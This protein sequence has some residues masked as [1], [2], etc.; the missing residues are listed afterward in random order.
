MRS[1]KLPRLGMA[2]APIRSQ[3]QGKIFDSAKAPIRYEPYMLSIPKWNHTLEW[4]N[5]LA[6]NK[7]RETFLEIEKLAESRANAFRGQADEKARRE[8][9]ERGRVRFFASA[10]NFG[11]LDRV[12]YNLSESRGDGSNATSISTEIERILKDVLFFSVVLEAAGP[13]HLDGKADKAI[14]VYFRGDEVEKYS[15]FEK[16]DLQPGDEVYFT[17]TPKRYYQRQR[18]VMQHYLGEY[19]WA[20]E[21]QSP[22]QLTFDDVRNVTKEDFIALYRELIEYW[23]VIDYRFGDGRYF[24][25][26]DEAVVEPIGAR[27]ETPRA[28][29]VKGGGERLKEMLYSKPLPKQRTHRLARR[30]DRVN[31]QEDTSPPPP[32]RL[33]RKSSTIRIERDLDPGKKMAVPDE[34]P[35]SFLDMD[36]LK[37]LIDSKDKYLEEYQEITGQWNSPKAGRAGEGLRKLLA[38][39]PTNHSLRAQVEEDERVQRRRY[40]KWEKVA[41]EKTGS[42][43]LH[44]DLKKRHLWPV[45]APQNML[46][47]YS[48]FENMNCSTL[49]T[50]S[51]PFEGF[52]VRVMRRDGWRK[53][54]ITSV[55]GMNLVRTKLAGPET[56]KIAKWPISIRFDDGVEGLY[57]YPCE[58]NGVRLGYELADGERDEYVKAWNGEQQARESQPK[59]KNPVVPELPKINGRKAG[60]FAIPLKIATIRDKETQFARMKAKRDRKAKMEQ[61]SLGE[62]WEDLKD[63]EAEDDLDSDDDE[64]ED[65]EES[66]NEDTT[67][68]DEAFKAKHS[69]MMLQKDN[70]I[71]DHENLWN[72]EYAE[73]RRRRKCLI[74]N[75]EGRPPAKA[76]ILDSNGKPLFIFRERKMDEIIAS[77]SCTEHS[78]SDFAGGIDDDEGEE[79]VYEAESEDGGVPAVKKRKKKSVKG[80]TTAAGA[81]NNGTSFYYDPLV[82]GEH[83]MMPHFRREMREY[84]KQHAIHFMLPGSRSVASP[85][86][87]NLLTTS[88]EHSEDVNVVRSIFGR[89]DDNPVAIPPGHL[90]PKKWRVGLVVGGHTGI[91]Y[92]I[93][94]RLMEKEHSLTLFIA[95]PTFEQA[96]KACEQLTQKAIAEA[97]P[98][99]IDLTSLGSIQRIAKVI[100]R[101][102]K[103]LDLLINCEGLVPPSPPPPFAN[104][105]QAAVYARQVLAREFHGPLRLVLELVKL[106]REDGAIM[107][108]VP[109]SALYA[110]KE[111]GPIKSL[112]VC[113]NVSSS[114]FYPP[115]G[116]SQFFLEISIIELIFAMWPFFKGVVK[117][118]LDP[119][120]TFRGLQGIARSYVDSIGSGS[121]M[122]TGY[123]LSVHAGAKMLMLALTR[124]LGAALG[125]GTGVAAV[126][127]RGGKNATAFACVPD[128]NSITAQ[129]GRY[130]ASVRNA[131]VAAGAMF[132]AQC[133]ASTTAFSLL[134]RKNVTSRSHN[135]ATFFNN[136]KIF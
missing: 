1:S 77:T 70:V 103:E 42:K 13:L 69:Q 67:E 101:D 109:A 125:E 18:R 133:E 28:A 95:A 94:H 91:G 34:R 123:P 75:G 43:I 47:M 46:R 83:W 9:R 68:D 39:M 40:R 17:L 79:E 112:S 52:G 129:Y 113:A 61:H 131:T 100:Q 33:P 41:Q 31:E 16:A 116:Q 36:L 12:W 27:F 11:I 127:G 37:K 73:R 35:K 49:H 58:S 21:N 54:V 88:S 92:A 45:A 63:E 2:K 120:Q 89:P 8:G 85:L 50:Y 87:S 19:G 99:Q 23:N 59:K 64:D 96:R 117:A 80:K 110:L 81:A 132:K 115:A 78:F 90:R 72:K 51:V 124:I 102:Y 130:A 86:P 48:F 62:G 114:V 53:G 6:R 106:L 119:S 5:Y 98:V 105:T 57:T 76:L 104:A 32:I 111:T 121:N 74:W 93:A 4:N 60:T 56:K 134:Q 25:P 118:M 20:I 65:E 26:D 107:H 7:R 135:G 38:K 44:E 15:E 108:M 136:A 10:K 97:I 84:K 30:K 3:V 82:H 128:E 29:L 22:Q 14:G 55:G 71:E 24:D 126:L 122:R 66:K